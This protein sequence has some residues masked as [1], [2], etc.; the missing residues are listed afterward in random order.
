MDSRAP[1]AAAL[2]RSSPPAVC[3][4]PMRRSG[5]TKVDDGD[6]DHS[7]FAQALLANLET[8]GLEI[9]LMFRKVR[10]QVL[11]RTNNAQEPFT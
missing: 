6:S 1:S 3:W 8:P 9:N 10:D 11:A 4:L 7:P 5:G 2:R